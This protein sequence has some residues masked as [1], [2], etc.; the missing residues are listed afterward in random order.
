MD[1]LQSPPGFLLISGEGKLHES[2]KS[3]FVRGLTTVFTLAG[4]AAYD[5]FPF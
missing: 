3:V 1:L 5:L 2:G 4:G